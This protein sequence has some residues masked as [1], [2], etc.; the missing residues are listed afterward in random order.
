MKG[1]C[2]NKNTTSFEFLQYTGDNT[3]EIKRILS[4]FKTK[5]VS[6]DSK[7]TLTC[8]DGWGNT[9]ILQVTDVVMLK[10]GE[11][12]SKQYFDFTYSSI[13]N[14]S[15]APVMFVSADVMEFVKNWG[16][17]CT[18]EEGTIY[19][20]NGKWFRLQMEA[21]Q[22]FASNFHQPPGFIEKQ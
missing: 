5:V 1:V 19:M 11:I 10:S 17:K 7:K 13:P 22:P 9:K 8:Y 4:K 14:Y 12:V 16:V 18:V 20:I 6:V 3:V 21:Q 15:K 2:H